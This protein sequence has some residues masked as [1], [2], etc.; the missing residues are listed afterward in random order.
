MF[1]RSWMIFIEGSGLNSVSGPETSEE[2]KKRFEIECEFV[3][4]LANPHYLNCW[5]FFF[6]QMIFLLNEVVH[7]TFYILSVLWLFIDGANINGIKFTC[8]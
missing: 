3:Q 1:Y 7:A 4:A 6:E 5:F 2:Q 8:K